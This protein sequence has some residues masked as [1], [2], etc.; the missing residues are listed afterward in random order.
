MDKPYEKYRE[1]FDSIKGTQLDLEYNRIKNTGTDLEYDEF[2]KKN[3]IK[4]TYDEDF[5]IYSLFSD[6]TL[7]NKP[8]GEIRYLYLK[9]LSSKD[10]IKDI[11]VVNNEKANTNQLIIDTT[12][13]KI[14]LLPLT[15]AIPKAK[16]VYPVLETI[17]RANTCFSNS[18]NISL[19]LSNRDNDVVTGIIHGLTD[20]S[21]YLHSWVETNLFGEDVVI[22]FTMNAIINKEGY[23]QFRHAEEIERINGKTIVEDSKNYGNMLDALDAHAALYNI[24]RDELVGDLDKN[25]FLNKK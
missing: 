15:E 7:E 22:D 17:A 24:F 8:L 12:K 19:S 2:I 13:G 21:K 4:E 10:Y 11:K 18:L 1:L 3:N 23:Y 6:Q 25:S 9:L 16:E 14:T 20:K 5:M